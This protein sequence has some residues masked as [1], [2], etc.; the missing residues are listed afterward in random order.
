[1]QHA[2]AAYNSLAADGKEFRA[3]FSPGKIVCIC[4]SK[5]AITI[6]QHSSTDAGPQ[7]SADYTHAH[8]VPH[9]QSVQ[10]SHLVPKGLKEL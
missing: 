1:M 3:T 5:R 10:I 4:C 8:T 6:T 2:A 7:T 9:A